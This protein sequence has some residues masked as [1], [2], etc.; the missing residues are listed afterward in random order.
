MKLDGFLALATVV[1][2]GWM[3]VVVAVR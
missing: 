1:L 3:L 2:F